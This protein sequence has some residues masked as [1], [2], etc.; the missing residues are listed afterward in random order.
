MYLTREEERIL[1]GEYGRAP[2]YAL[3]LQIRFGKI[4]DAEQMVPIKHAHISCTSIRIE[5]ALVPWLQELVGMGAKVRVP[6]TTMV[7]GCDLRNWREIGFDES[8]V[9]PVTDK[10]EVQLGTLYKMGITPTHTC[11]PYWLPGLQHLPG[12]HVAWCESSAIIYG[13]TVQALRMNRECCQSAL[14]AGI[15]GR[16]P[17]FGYHLTENRRG[18]VHVKVEADVKTGAD[19]SVMGFALSD[20]MGLEVPVFTGLK[21]ATPG[22]LANLSA[23]FTTRSGISMFHVVGVTPE[24]STFEA[25]M[26]GDKPKETIVFTDNDLK[27]TYREINPQEPQEIDWVYLGCPHFTINQI[28]E[29][30]DLLKGKKIK[31]GITFLVGTCRSIKDLADQLGYTKTI[32]EAGGHI[33]CDCCGSVQALLPNPPKVGM[34]DA[35]KQV[36]YPKGSVPIIG[37]VKESVD[38]AISGKWIPPS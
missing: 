20:D 26:Q 30:A 14:L 5:G 29:V 22:Y 35:M 16:T 2:Q 17:Y 18:T 27:K 8:K 10:L 3:E 9:T 7:T 34:Y 11:V 12:D 13:N 37:S 23:A 31:S 4:F 24:A 15:T 1:A 19:Y 21:N 38:A 33:M 6:S 28:Q 36:Y 25:A 32:E